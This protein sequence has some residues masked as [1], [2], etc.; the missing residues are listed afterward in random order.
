MT[1]PLLAEWTGLTG[2]GIL[3]LIGPMVTTPVWRESTGKRIAAALSYPVFLALNRPSLSWLAKA[4]YDFGLRLN[5]IAINFKGSHGLNIAE[6]RFL[7]R[8]ADRIGSGVV[9][10][11]GAHHG[12]Y[13]SFIAKL[14]PTAKIYAFEPHPKTCAALRVSLGLPA[15]EIIEAA[16]SDNPGTFQLH[17]FAKSDGSTQASL[18]KRAVE[19]FDEDVVTYEVAVSTID[20]FM[21]ERGI[22]RIAFLKVDTEGFDLAVLRGARQ[23]IAERRI[24]TIQFEFIPAN[25]VTGATMRGFF[26]A[27]PGYEILR[28][29]L[30]GSLLPLSPY[31]VKRCEIYVTHNLI[32]LPRRA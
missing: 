13:S 27:L 7:R 16:L 2:P 4:T 10:D 29:C 15:V 24:D 19:F 3:R 11:V 1:Q 9:L 6:E 28:L 14:A 23:A 20:G 17:D 8:M 32:A 30:N 12:D 31:D 22:D 25:I 26:E 21:A 5:G 18:S